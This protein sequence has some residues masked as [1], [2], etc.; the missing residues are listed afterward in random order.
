MHISL[1]F[2]VMI[3]IKKNIFIF[4]KPFHRTGVNYERT[5]NNKQKKR[6]SYKLYS[7][8]VTML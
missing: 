8:Y 7:L 6:N 1:P 5:I 3:I 2:W 4:T